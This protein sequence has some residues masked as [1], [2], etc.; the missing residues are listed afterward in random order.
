[1]AFPELVIR[2][3]QAQ[4]VGPVAQ[5]AAVQPGR[6]SAGDR[7]VE[8]GDLLSH[9]GERATEKPIRVGLVRVSEY[10]GRLVFRHP[11]T[12]S[13]IV[14]MSRSGD[15]RRA[16]RALA[17][18]LAGQPELQA[19]HLAAAAAG[20]DEKA[21]DLLEQAADQLIRRGDA[22][23]A[24]TAL[25]RAADLS[26][27]GPG[28]S[29]RLTAAAYAGATVTMEVSGVP[30]LLA[31][32]RRADPGP[33]GSLPAAVTAAH[34]LLNGDGDIDTAH[35]LLAEAIDAE[36]EP[37]HASGDTMIQAL[38]TLMAVCYNGGRAELWPAFDEAI[39]RLA[40][41]VPADLL[42][43]RQTLADPARTAASALGDLDTA[44]RSL[45]DEMDHWRIMTISAAALFPD[46]LAGCRE[47]LLRVVRD[48][49][50]GGAVTPAVSALTNLSFD[51]LMAGRWD[52][53]QQLADEGLELASASN[54]RLT[55]WLF[56]HRKG[57]LAAA[58][59]DLDT[60]QAL[61]DEIIQWAAPRGAGLAEAHARHLGVLAALAQGDFENAYQRAAAISPPGM[62]ASH[63][64]LALWV[65]MDLVEAAVRTG[66]REQ[67]AA[68]VTA[69]RNAGI[70]ALSPR[71]ALLATASEAIAAPDDI[72]PGLFVTAL[73]VPGADRFP[74]DL[75][76]V[77]LAY[78]VLQQRIQAM[79]AGNPPHSR[80]PQRVTELRD[81]RLVQV[82]RANAAGVHPA[83]QSPGHRQHAHDR[84]RGIAPT[85]Q[86]GTVSLD[87][88]SHPAR[89]PAPSGHDRPPFPE[90]P[91][92]TTKASTRSRNYAGPPPPPSP[93]PSP[94]PAPLASRCGRLGIVP[95]S[96]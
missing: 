37:C 50:A 95:G 26:P 54:Y 45:P 74:F 55:V 10:T 56:H 93:F 3:V 16:H 41:H 75:G 92:P 89:L 82:T 11:L 17:D 15:R 44:I 13:A 83:T 24:V 77:L 36:A 6:Q 58:R 84:A 87:E 96:A 61:A 73:A 14:E 22:T 2:V 48:G 12:R 35:R 69:I 8:R 72:A 90:R 21:A 25:L 76:R 46:R 71:L 59:G 52:Q 43:L 66:R 47:A 80:R 64:P 4:R 88:G 18:H 79:S 63:V 29:R 62:L 33:G 53:A 94:G 27:D 67:A 39:S 38:Q 86:P 78:Q 60:A 70:A 91:A 34:L 51:D 1:M 57:F 9:R 30:R 7:Q 40:P 49:L 81:R 68:H 65:A 28:R 5:V 23:G 20:P 19:W 85:R 32:A 42:L 31:T